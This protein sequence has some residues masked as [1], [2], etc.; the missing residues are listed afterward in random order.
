MVK[1]KT[2]R[3]T[4]SHGNIMGATYIHLKFFIRHIKKSKNKHEIN[5][6]HIFNHYNMQ[7]IVK[8]IEIFDIPFFSFHTRALKLCRCFTH[9]DMD[10]WIGHIL[11]T[12]VSHVSSGR[13]S[14]LHSPG[15]YRRETERLLSLLTSPCP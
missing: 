4:L 13:H 10:I 1:E 7:F 5:C 11:H 14:G 2:S 9:R 8:I 12:Q 15:Q 6:N 3:P